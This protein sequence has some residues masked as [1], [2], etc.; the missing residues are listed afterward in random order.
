MQLHAR[1][2]THA[3][4]CQSHLT[5]LKPDRETVF[6]LL[7]RC[8]SK[9]E[10]CR[11][12]HYC[13]R[14]LPA[15]PLTAWKREVIQS[16]RSRRR[17]AQHLTDLDKPWHNLFLSVSHAGFSEK[18]RR[19]WTIRTWNVVLKTNRQQFYFVYTLTS[20]KEMTSEYSK[21]GLLLWSTKV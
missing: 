13:A 18:L 3:V 10:P 20:T 5:N 8:S 9:R 12:F 17:F 2:Y 6:W 7:S 16:R 11:F 4:S 19:K 14:L 1:T 15:R 21:G